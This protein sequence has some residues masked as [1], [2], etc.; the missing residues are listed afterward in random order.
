M[1]PLTIAIVGL[2]IGGL[3]L[4]F[5][6][7]SNLVALK[8]LFSRKS[9]EQTPE[10][11]LPDSRDLPSAISKPNPTAKFQLENLPIPHSSHL[12]GRSSEKALLTREWKNRESRNIL[13]LI[14][15]GGTGKSFLVSRW[16]AE[17]KVK[18][19]TPYAGAQRI[20]TW[21]CF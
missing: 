10:Q 2:V 8:Q 7:P 15:E 14:A 17:L 4:L 1:D 20:F 21:S 6:I 3:A 12:I 16:L 19:P 18:A 13:A 9:S 5:G 11:I